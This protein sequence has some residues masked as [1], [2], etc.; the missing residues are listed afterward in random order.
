MRPIA[1]Y[2]SI[3]GLEGV[4][5]G[6]YNLPALIATFTALLEADEDGEA[7]FE[8]RQ[9]DLLLHNL[10]YIPARVEY[11]V[12]TVGT[13]T[14]R[15]LAT[16]TTADTDLFKT[17]I[18][19]L[20]DALAGAWRTLDSDTLFRAVGYRDV[21]V[22]T[23]SDLA[24]RLRDHVD[25]RLRSEPFYLGAFEADPGNPIQ[26][27]ISVD[28][29]IHRSDYRQR[30][31]LFDPWS[32]EDPLDPPPLDL[33][34]EEWY[35][36]LDFAGVRYLTPEEREDE[37]F[38][39]RW[40]ER[41]HSERGCRSAEL[42]A[43]R[44]DRGHLARLAEEAARIPVEDDLLPFAIEVDAMPLAADAEVDREKLTGY[45]LNPQHERGRDKARWFKAVL[46]IET[47]DWRHLSAQLRQGL[48]RAERIERVRS[49]PYGV[50][51]NVDTPINGIN[52]KVAL[53]TSAWEVVDGQPPRLITAFPGGIH[54][55]DATAPPTL[56][57]PAAMPAAERWPALWA[58]AEDYA[59]DAAAGIAPTP[60]RIT[61]GVSSE[62]VPE[63]AFGF[64]WVAV[65]D[66]RRGFARWLVRSGKAHSE[67]GR[68]AMLMAP[69][70]RYDKARAWADAFVE[71]LGFNGIDAVA[72][73]EL[74]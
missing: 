60:M 20:D 59:N 12:K 25:H 27:H 54:D 57:V 28:T 63:G 1:F 34:G 23:M 58:L 33:H 62:W 48:L 73:S 43:R 38:V 15:S 24:P 21:Y 18:W 55:G 61:D 14:H 17:L 72:T 35:L 7:A 67:H 46:G 51:Y 71:V 69:A 40:R 29:L 8:L 39:L 30:W 70:S 36:G 9:G 31:L 16:H 49:T 10:C 22:L 19:D 26:R 6:S 74:D 13:R 41:P 52:G 45:L 50:Q 66:A 53:V 32:S 37:E 64:A 47:N 56:T 2:F 5:D 44:T 42:L 3:E 65:R 11:E 4:A 68:G